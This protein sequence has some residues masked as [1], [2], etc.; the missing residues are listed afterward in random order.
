MKTD[1]VILALSPTYIYNMVNKKKKTEIY[2][3]P[4]VNVKFFLLRPNL[5]RN[6]LP[7]TKVFESCCDLIVSTKC[8]SVFIKPILIYVLNTLSQYEE[9]GKKKLIKF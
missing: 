2:C 1:K 9:N 3:S 5:M 4:H 7:A 6:L 8:L